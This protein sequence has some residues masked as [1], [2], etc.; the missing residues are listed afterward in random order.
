MLYQLSYAPVV[1]RGDP[2]LFITASA[3]VLRLR[4]PRVRAP[5]RVS[6]CERSGVRLSPSASLGMSFVEACE[7]TS[8][9]A[10]LVS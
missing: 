10:P 2:P 3:R 6:R 1:A 7:S 8:F 9:N 4:T 5:A